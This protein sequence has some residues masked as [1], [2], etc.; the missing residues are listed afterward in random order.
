MKKDLNEAIKLTGKVIDN[1]LPLKIQYDNTPGTVV[2]ISVN[3]VPKYIRA[4]GVEDIAT[5]ASMKKDAQFRVAS[6]SK[7][8]TAVAV[9]QLQERN[10]L[11]IDD[12]VS[13]YLTWFKG[14]SG[15][16]D[17]TN[18]TIRQLLSHNAGLFRDGTA[19]QWINDSFPEKLADTISSKSVI[20]ENATTFKY[21]NHGYAILGALIEKVSGSSYN[22][23]VTEHILKKLGLKNTLPDLTSNS[24]KKLIPGFERLMPGKEER[25]REPEIKTH[26]YA[27]ATGFVSD[28]KDLAIFLASLHL[29][30]KN[31]VLSRE[32]RKEMVRVHGIPEE[33]E[34]YG[35]GLSLDKASGKL[36]YGHSGGFAGFTTNAICE[37]NDNLQVIVLSN[38]ISNTAWTVSNNTIGLIYKLLEMKDLKNIVDEPYSGSYRSRWGDL[39]IASIGN[40]LVS[41]SSNSSNPVKAWS[42]LKKKKGHTFVDME[43]AGFGSPGEEVR[44]SK[45]KAGKMQVMSNDSSVWERIQ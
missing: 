4:F 15:K 27:P 31:S 33:D 18:V 36:A 9:M 22:K 45:I 25:C 17:L 6:M 39:T 38:T 43:K 42:E 5:N 8:F 16:T 2:C 35:L 12:K 10:K 44:F 3:G 1:W 11:R 19:K 21:S 20:F 34:M 26:T 41:F 24:P 30:S 32:S 13:K 40:D 23:Y 14:K 29:D 37:P 28:V 7:M